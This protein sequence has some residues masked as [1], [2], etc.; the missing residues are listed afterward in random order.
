MA[1]PAAQPGWYPDPVVIGQLRWWDGGQWTGNIHAAPGFT[2]RYTGASSSVR[3]APADL[4]DEQR[5]ARTASTALVFGAAI[6]VVLYVTA[7]VLYHALF[8]S[9]FSQIHAARTAPAQ[10]FG[11]TSS[12]TAPPF[13]SGFLALSGL[14]QLVQVGYLAVGALFLGWFYKAARLAE[15]AGLPARRSHGLATAGFVIPIV[16]LWW[17]YQSTRDLFVAGDQRRRR[18][19]RWWF[20]WIATQFASIIVLI[21]ALGSVPVLVLVTLACACLPIA[22]A[23]AARAV[24]AG[25]AEAHADLVG[26]SLG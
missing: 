3:S 22:A 18:V 24:I 11:S 21:A 2:Y 8:H 23:V 1:G 10:P 12:A 19:G 13:P 14:L 5:A 26:G 20:L 16:S 7:A 9:I 4:A 25:V 17:P 6:Y 15:A